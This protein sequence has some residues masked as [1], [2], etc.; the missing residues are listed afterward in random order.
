[1]KAVFFDFDGTLTQNS[2]NIWKSM[3]KKCG[4]YMGGNS[5]FNALYKQFISSE[6][7]YQEWCDLT[8]EIFKR[9]KFSKKD[10]M[11]LTNQVKL[12][13]G[14][15]ETLKALKQNGY[16]LFVVS[17][18]FTSVIKTALGKNAKYFD[19]IMANSIKFDKNGII[20]SIKGTNYDFEGKA[21]F[22]NEYK[23]ATKSNPKDLFFVGNGGNDEW[24]HLSGCST[25]CINPDETDSLNGTKWHKSIEYTD[26][27]TS[28]LSCILPQKNKEVCK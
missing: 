1:M 3:W 28:I 26:N 18:G 12:I 7:S 2:P 15:E 9:A 4:C 21:K 16:H 19:G 22:I 14:V 23:V 25:I 10:L 6:I 11:E 17:G 27:L 5:Y 24:A 8:C 20:E 13:G